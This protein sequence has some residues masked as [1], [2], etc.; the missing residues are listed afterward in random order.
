MLANAPV[1]ALT[2]KEPISISTNIITCLDGMQFGWA[3]GQYR[4]L[5]GF[6][7][8]QKITYKWVVD[9]NG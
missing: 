2:A 7:G 5:V 1:E 3:M 9:V 4:S 8:N 6:I